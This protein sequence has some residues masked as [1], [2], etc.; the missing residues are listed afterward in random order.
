LKSALTAVLIVVLCL[1]PFLASAPRVNAQQSSSGGWP[2][3]RA[4]PSH[5]GLGTGRPA[6]APRPLWNYTTGSYLYSSPA[7]IN[8]VVYVGS[9]DG[10]IYALNATNGTKIWNYTM[11]GQVLSSPAVIDGKVYVGSSDGNVY[12]LNADTGDKLWN[13]TTA[14]SSFFSGFAG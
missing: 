7:I 6:L 1:S 9:F 2:M 14:R 5:S 8:G 12:A 13:F 3:F 4:D 11:G 10:N